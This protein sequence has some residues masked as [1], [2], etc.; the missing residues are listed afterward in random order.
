M[1][2]LRPADLDDEVESLPISCELGA[3]PSVYSE[4][5]YAIAAG[6]TVIFTVDEA[7]AKDDIHFDTSHYQHIIWKDAQELQSRS[8]A[9]IAAIL[10][11]RRA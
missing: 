4:A 6:K 11:A 3:R 2:W 10:A 7:S 1:P 8:A 9:R 5:G